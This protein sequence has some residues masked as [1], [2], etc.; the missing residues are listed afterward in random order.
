MITGALTSP[1]VTR[2]RVGVGEALAADLKFAAGDG[3]RGSYL[4]DLRH[5]RR[6]I[7]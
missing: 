5:G 7:F 2:G 4:R 1:I 6:T 3:R